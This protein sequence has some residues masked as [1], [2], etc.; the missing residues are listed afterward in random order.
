MRWGARR[1]MMPVVSN[2]QITVPTQVSFVATTPPGTEPQRILPDAVAPAVSDAAL[3]K[4]YKGNGGYAGAASAPAP[5]SLS[6]PNLSSLIPAYFSTAS[7]TLS[8]RAMFAT[9]L[10]SQDA[11]GGTEFFAVYEELVA[12]AQV[13][14]KPSNAAM[15]EP[16]PNNLFA[17]MLVETQNQNVRVA[18]QIQQAPKEVAAQ[19]AVPQAPPPKATPV[20]RQ[21]SQAQ[22]AA[23][24]RVASHAY[25]TTSVRNKVELES[26]SAE[27]VSG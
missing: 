19:A 2:T 1:G 3:G 15:P 8:P 10:L 25:Q 12:A 20:M 26:E 16:A 18:A 22:I 9:Q 6:S 17:K 11:Q 23:A 7:A 5:S 14:Y 13:K 24:A 21:K 27:P 4:D